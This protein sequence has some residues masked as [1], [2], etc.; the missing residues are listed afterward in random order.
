MAE[1]YKPAIPYYMEV[2]IHVIP[3]EVLREVEQIYLAQIA[4]VRLSG[5][6][7]SKRKRR[8]Y[9]QLVAEIARREKAE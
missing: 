5:S 7:S 4:A 8:R 3:T 9:D 6:Q 1:D 2:P